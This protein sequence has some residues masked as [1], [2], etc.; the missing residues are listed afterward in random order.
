MKDAKHIL[1]INPGSTSTKL[2]LFRQQDAVWQENLEHIPEELKPF[3]RVWQQLEFRLQLIEAHLSQ[4][5]LDYAELAA[6]VGRG[7][8]LKPME[9]GTYLVNQ[10][11]LK[12]ARAGLQG[13]HGANLGCALAYDIAQKA[14]VSAYVVDPI[15]VDEFEP[16]ARYSGH[17]LIERRCLS[18]ALNIHAVT[19]KAAE[20]LEVEYSVSNFIVAHLGG[21][22]S[23][24]PVRGGK[25][26]DVNDASSAGPFSPERT[27]GLPL[28]PFIKLCFS[29][30][31]SENEMRRLVMGNGGLRAYL[32]TTSKKEV[33][34]RIQH[35]DHMAAEVYQAMIY[36]I[37][38]EIGAMATVLHGNV[39]AIVLTGGLAKS[40]IV[41]QW[42]K[43]RVGFIA[44]VVILPG[45]FEMEAMNLGVLR[46]LEGKET[47]KIY[48]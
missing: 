17:P 41:T 37:A 25:I 34:D 31:Y 13:E 45:E 15:S 23:V 12:D 42:I 8:L 18:H 14:G 10:Q 29:G 39:R 47:A 46:V 16:L 2:A 7:G 27:G 30:K 11:M 26:V 20:M 32:G 9:G 40:Q 6:V 3:D 36:Q 38:K 5:Q 22:I 35:G 19:R 33:E 44:E 1:V 21:G 24:A 28:Q 4:R 48:G 43:E